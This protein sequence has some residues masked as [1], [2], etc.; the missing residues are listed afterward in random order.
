MIQDAKVTGTQ[1]IDLRNQQNQTKIPENA[2]IFTNQ[3]ENNAIIND[4]LLIAET[5]DSLENVRILAKMLS[6]HEFRAIYFQNQI[7]RPYYLTGGGTHEQFV[8]L[9]KTIRQ[10]PEFDVRYKLKKL[11]DFLKIPD[12]LLIKM[13]QIFEEL[14]FITLRDGLMTV[15]QTAKKRQFSDSQIYQELQ[16]LIKIQTFFALSPV[17]QIYQKLKENNLWI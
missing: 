14:N 7:K 15:N 13:V 4:I 1:L 16:A 2:F 8:K 3:L 9:Y 11:A 17:R 12:I 10:Y 5:P 6:E